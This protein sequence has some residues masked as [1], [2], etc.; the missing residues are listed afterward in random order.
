MTNQEIKIIKKLTE[1]II[2]EAFSRGLS[3]NTIEE[4][5]KNIIKES[6]NPDRIAGGLTTEFLKKTNKRSK[7]DKTSLVIF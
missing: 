2:Q 1:E 6:D 4:L 7:T 5:G 3:L